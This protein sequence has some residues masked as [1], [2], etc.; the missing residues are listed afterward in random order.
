MLLC[1]PNAT[2][3][4]C[5][6]DFKSA[7]EDALL[8]YP[9]PRYS[10]ERPKNRSGDTDFGSLKV[11]NKQEISQ[12]TSMADSVSVLDL[13]LM[14]L[15]VWLV[16]NYSGKQETQFYGKYFDRFY[17]S[18]DDVVGVIGQ[19]LFRKVCVYLFFCLISSAMRKWLVT[20]L[21]WLFVQEIYISSLNLGYMFDFLSVCSSSIISWFSIK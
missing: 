4:F 11:D 16:K 18:P 17:L 10:L 7:M 1:F 9:Q 13:T 6:A 3:P 14:M 19:R 20:V 12:N 21:E 5:L 15:P 8:P 2:R